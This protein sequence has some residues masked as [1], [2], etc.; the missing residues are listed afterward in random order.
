MPPQTQE[1]IETEMLKRVGIM[2]KRVP[3]AYDE[4]LH[5]ILLS[6]LARFLVTP[7]EEEDPILKRMEW[8]EREVEK[9]KTKEKVKTL[10]SKADLVYLI[11]KDEL[12]K[13]H[14]GKI[15]AIDVK[16]KKI[17]GLGSSILEAYQK[18]KEKTGRKQFSYRRIGFPFVHKL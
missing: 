6:R 15:V 14:Y 13:E 18:A 17:V 8:L 10:P 9:L 1:E 3:Y 2:P 12:E 11:F 16:S 4:F 5:K 7:V